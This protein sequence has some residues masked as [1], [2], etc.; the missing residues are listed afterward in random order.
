M[1]RE[2]LISIVAILCAGTAAAQTHVGGFINSDTRWMAQDGPFIVGSNIFVS[3]DATLTIDPGAEVQFGSN[4]GITIVA[5]ELVA[6]GTESEKITFT[7]FFNNSPWTNIKFNDGTFNTVLGDSGNYISGSIIEYAIIEKGGLSSVSTKISVVQMDRSNVFVNNS[8]I[9]HNRGGGI[10]VDVAD[11][12]NISSNHLFNNGG[13][14]ISLNN[15]DGST[16]GDN[17]ILNSTYAGISVF[18][19][20]GTEISRNLIKSNSSGGISITSGSAIITDNTIDENFDHGVQV[21]GDAVFS[22]NTISNGRS[23]Y[24]LDISGGSFTLSGDRIFNNVIGGVIASGN[25]S[26]ILSLDPDNPTQIFGNAGYQLENK[27]GFIGPNLDD[28]GNIDA[29]NVFWG[30]LGFQSIEPNIF[31]NSDDSDRGVIFYTP[32]AVM[33]WPTSSAAWM[34]LAALVNMGTLRTSRSK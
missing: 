23:A 12:I 33:P 27:S 19:G 11:D 25:S 2:R 22:N 5:G 20:S 15:V 4:S 14:G 30:N 34:I 16:I 9:R 29:R 10:H 28:P 3:N 13:Y 1:S 6:R 18:G 7:S 24:G 31:H 17:E 32:I 26:I 8:T 21:K